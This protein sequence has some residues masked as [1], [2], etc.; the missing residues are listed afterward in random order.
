MSQKPKFPP[1]GDEECVINISKE[2]VPSD[3][4]LE[5]VGDKSVVALVSQDSIS[6]YLRVGGN[7]ALI[8]DTLSAPAI[9][10]IGCEKSFCKLGSATRPW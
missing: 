4:K 9:L 6:R 5:P 2:I 7:A 8:A 3:L 1:G 10:Q